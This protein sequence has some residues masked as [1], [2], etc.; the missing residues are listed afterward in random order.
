MPQLAF[1]IVNVFTRGASLSGNPLCVFEDGSLVDDATMQALAR[2]FNLSETTFILPSAKATARVRIFTPGYEMPFAGHPTL[3]TAHVVRALGRAGDAVALEMKAGIIPVNARGDRWTLQA[4]EPR[5]RA[6]E[7]ARQARQQKLDARVSPWSN[8]WV[9]GF[10]RG[11]LATELS[12]AWLVGALNNWVAP[13][14]RG[15]WRAAQ[16][17]EGTHVAYGGAFYAIPRRSDPSRKALAW[18][19]IHLMTLD[20]ERQ[21]QAFKTHD[22]FPALLETHDDAFFEQ[23][24]PFLAGQPARL[25]WRTAARRIGATPVHKQNGFADEVVG[26]ELD[27]VLDR[28]KDIR[29][30]LADAQRLLERRARR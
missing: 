12:G 15:L 6:F 2:Q 16:L 1:R 4:I 7:L 26:T 8:E 23:P 30:A 3:G 9:E 19:F 29:A 20:R 21:L 11:T 22:A 25:L 13:Q 10:K 5:S 27:N 24:V 28:G 14:T 18:E 17:P